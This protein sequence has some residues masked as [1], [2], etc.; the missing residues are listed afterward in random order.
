MSDS[1]R[2]YGLHQSPL[3]MGFSRQEYWRGLPC[4]SPG[5]LSDPG[6]EPMSLTSPAL[7]DGFFTT[8]TTWETPPSLSWVVKSRKKKKFIN[9]EPSIIV[10][11]KGL[12]R[13]LIKK[14]FTKKQHFPWKFYK[15]CTNSWV[16]S[17][18]RALGCIQAR[19]DSKAYM[20]LNSLSACLMLCISS[21][22]FYKSSNSEKDKKH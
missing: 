22:C 14:S 17:M 13:V 11:K 2:P 19:E 15:M 1:L 9:K 21:L 20:V 4:P 10:F 8:S 12:F 16:L 3:S 18:S 5:D 6:I 7:V